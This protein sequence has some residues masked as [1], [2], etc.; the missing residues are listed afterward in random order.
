M[1]INSSFYRPHRQQTYARWAES[2][3]EGF[4][5]SVKM[6]KQITHERRLASCGVLLEEFL[7]QCSGLGERLGCLLVQLPPSLVFEEAAAQSFFKTLREQ[8]AGPVVLEPRHA[9]WA[10]ADPLLLAWQITRAG[11]DPARFDT[12]A[13]PGGTGELR[14]WRLHGSPRLYYSAYEPAYLENL[15]GQMQI[16]AAEGATVWCVFDNTASGAAL[17]NALDLS[18]LCSRHSSDPDFIV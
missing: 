3:P 12:D 18:R 10:N 16:A 6:P 14:Y 1:E 15:A 7:Q 5:F 9:S 2:V 8:Y 4:R 13:S 17:R 11:V